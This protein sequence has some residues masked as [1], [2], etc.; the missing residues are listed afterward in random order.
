MK[1]KAKYLFNRLVGVVVIYKQTWAKY[2]VF[3]LQFLKCKIEITG[4][5]LFFRKIT[6]KFM[7]KISY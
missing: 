1:Q 4:N 7:C 2:N 6:N 5:L 3:L